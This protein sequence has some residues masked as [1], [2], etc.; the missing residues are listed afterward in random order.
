VRDPAKRGLD[1]VKTESACQI[2]ACQLAGPILVSGPGRLNVA[3]GA[4]G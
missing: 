3:G 4:E 2:D 1:T